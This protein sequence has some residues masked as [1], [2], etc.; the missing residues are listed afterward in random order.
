MTGMER[1]LRSFFVVN[2]RSANGAVGKEWPRIADLL[3]SELGSAEFG[4]TSGP[5]DAAHIAREALRRGF[6]MVVSVGGD[7]TNNE[8][9]N[10]FFDE[11]GRPVSP[12]AVFGVLC[13]GTG[14]DFRKTLKMPMDLKRQVERLKGASAMKADAGRLKFTDHSGAEAVRY[15]INITSFGIGGLVDEKVNTTTKVFGGKAS[16]MIGTLRAFLEYRNALVT[17]RIDERPEETVRVNNV[18]VCNGRYFGGGMWVAPKALLDDG[19]FDVVIF[20]DIGLRKFITDGRRIYA[21]THLDMD[22]VRFLRAKRVEARSDER[23]L[24]D[25]DG[26]QPGRLP[27]VIEMLEGAI[28]IKT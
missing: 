28:K 19:L 9:V 8:V 4:M 27:A 25:V 10:G 5:M 23:V 22:G 15:F 12:E 16:F 20:G 18:A 17:L 14:G 6:E 24:L 7:G 3:R 26:E 11:Q 1:N 13:R 21:G 2:P